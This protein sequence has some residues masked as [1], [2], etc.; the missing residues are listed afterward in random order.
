MQHYRTLQILRAATLPVRV[1]GALVIVVCIVLLWSAIPVIGAVFLTRLPEVG[2]VNLPDTE[3]LDTQYA[4]AMQDSRDTFEGRSPFFVPDRQ[5]EEVTPDE[6]D[7]PD[8]GYRPYGGPKLVGLVGARAYF[9]ERLSNGEQF[10]DIG[11]RAGNLSLVRIRPPWYADV[12]WNSYDYEIALF[13]IT[14]P[15]YAAPTGDSGNGDGNLFGTGSRGNQ[16]SQEVPFGRR[17]GRGDRLFDTSNDDIGI[18]R[19]NDL[20]I[21]PEDN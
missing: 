4:S 9:D 5:L 1:V 13:D 15:I 7:E 20:F 19:G 3:A 11:Q 6:P 14:G 17:G 12:R 8:T 10:L 2:T 21:Q 18:P 16:R